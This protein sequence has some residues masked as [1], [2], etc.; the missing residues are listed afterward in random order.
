MT[1]GHQKSARPFRLSGMKRGRQIAGFQLCQASREP[2]QRS[3]KTEHP[4]IVFL[5]ANSFSV[6]NLKFQ[7]K[8]GDA[9]FQLPIAHGIICPGTRS[10]TLFFGISSSV[11]CGQ[12]LPGGFSDSGDGEIQSPSF[13][14][15]IHRNPARSR[16]PLQKFLHEGGRTGQGSTY[17]RNP[18]GGV[19]ANR[20][21][22][23]PPIS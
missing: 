15:L 21:S 12:C 5:V 7:N 17:Q 6:K 14:F 8:V 4:Q 10:G 20:S 22:V 23:M 13:R 18:T 1:C 19:P 16:A 11:P 9:L 3:S 2:A